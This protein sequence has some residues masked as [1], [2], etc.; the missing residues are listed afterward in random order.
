MLFAVAVVASGCGSANEVTRDEPAPAPA[1]AQESPAAP[2]LEPAL[3]EVVLDARLSVEGDTVTVVGVTNLPTGAVLVWE[4]AE[5]VEVFG[6]NP[7]VTLRDADGN[8]PS[9]NVTVSDGIYAFEV[10]EATWADLALCDALPL[11]LFVAYIPLA[12]VAALGAVPDQP[13]ELYELHGENGERI[14]GAVAPAELQE[15]RGGERS[16]QLRVGCP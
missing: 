3:P 7:E 11:E 15:R 16:V 5:T 6:L 4:L 10:S 14:P 9:G 2:E 1:P 13:S 8:V 12:G